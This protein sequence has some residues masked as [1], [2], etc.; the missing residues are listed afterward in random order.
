[1]AP[2][3]A[4]ARY[5]SQLGGQDPLPGARGAAAVQRDGKD[6][7]LPVLQLVVEPLPHGQVKAAPSPRRPG[8]KEDFPASVVA[9]RVHS[10][11][12]IGQPEIWRLQRAQ[13]L[14]AEPGLL[15]EEPH[16]V[17][18]GVD[19]RLFEPPGKGGQIEACGTLSHELPFATLGNRDALAFPADAFGP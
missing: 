4:V 13:R 14:T 5:A 15:A 18:I 16:A 19:H 7:E 10:A 6:N 3:S 11:L 9:E 1:V 17:D 2:D 12:E 8:D